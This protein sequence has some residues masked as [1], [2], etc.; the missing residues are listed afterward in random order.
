MMEIAIC[1]VFFIIGI[2]VGMY[3]SSQIK[4]DINNRTK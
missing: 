2:V 4:D 3:I 1:M